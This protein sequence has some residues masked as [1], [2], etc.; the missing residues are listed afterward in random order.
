M[1]TSLNQLYPSQLCLGCTRNWKINPWT[2]SVLIQ[3][4]LF[5]C[6]YGFQ[7]WIT[8]FLFLLGFQSQ[9][10]KF[11]TFKFRKNPLWGP[12]KPEW[13]T[14]IFT[15]EVWVIKFY[16]LYIFKEKVRFP[17]TYQSE[18]YQ[19]KCHQSLPIQRA[20]CYGSPTIA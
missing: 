11:Q 18:K 17:R 3:T 9:S 6:L 20:Y 7:I 12:I 2:I 1:K 10:I 14:P 5:L 19:E 16:L 15:L 8:L 13:K 4:F